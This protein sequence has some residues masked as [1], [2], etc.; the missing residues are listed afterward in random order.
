M[1]SLALSPTRHSLRTTRVY[2]QMCPFCR[3]G[4]L[5]FNWRYCITS[6]HYRQIHTI[7][8]PLSFS[9]MY[10]LKS[11]FCRN[12]DVCPQNRSLQLV[13]FSRLFSYTPQL[14]YFFSRTLTASATCF[15]VRGSEI[16]AISRATST[17]SGGRLSTLA[18]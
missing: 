5:F 8:V 9:S 6:F 18:P 16:L 7:K 15:L 1:I 3:K 4:T 14:K 12:D 10:P 2:L 11:N 13:N 17:A